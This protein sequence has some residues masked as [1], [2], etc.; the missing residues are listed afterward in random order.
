MNNFFRAILAGA[1]AKKFGGGCLGTVV[2][3]I[4]VWVALGQCASNFP[5]N[6]HPKPVIKEKT[7]QSPTTHIGTHRPSY[8]WAV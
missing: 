7:I 6:K 3:F 4:I 8:K 1:A 2:V 5:A